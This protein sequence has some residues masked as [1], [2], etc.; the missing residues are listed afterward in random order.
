MFVLPPGAA[1]WEDRSAPAM[2]WWTMD[3]TVD[4]FDRDQRTWY[5][6]VFS[7][8][9]RSPAGNDG[10]MYRTIDR[11]HSWTRI[12]DA[13]RAQFLAVD[14]RHRDHGFLTTETQGLFETRNLQADQPTFRSVDG[15]PFRQP[16][17]VFFNPYQPREVWA[18]SF[19]GGLR[20]VQQP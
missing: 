1:A 6:G 15:Y 14:P 4:P 8:T 16:T 19:G 12:N 18:T 9:A 13:Y 17:R 11:G 2:H 3:L 5:V 10:G 7:H 20:V